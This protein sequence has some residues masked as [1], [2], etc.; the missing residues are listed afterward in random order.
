MGGAG[1]AVGQVDY[2]RYFKDLCLLSV[3]IDRRAATHRPRMAPRGYSHR[4][5]AT[6]RD[7]HPGG[8]CP[9]QTE[10]TTTIY[11]YGG[12]ALAHRSPSADSVVYRQRSRLVHRIAGLGLLQ[13]GM[14][15]VVPVRGGGCF[16]RWVLY[17]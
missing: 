11:Q 9:Q 14:P 5:K 4:G 17:A 6:A 16:V 2:A 8:G 15:V 1:A 13:T 10:P 12:P 7:D 3:G